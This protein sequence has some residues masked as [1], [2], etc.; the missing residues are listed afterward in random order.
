[1][2]FDQ[3]PS[4]SGH[5]FRVQR[6][7]GPVWYAKYRLPGGRQVKRKIGPAWTQR[8]RPAAGFA[9]KRIAEQWLGEVLAEARERSVPGALG[10]EATFADAAHEWLRYV[11]QDRACKP[12]TMRGYRSSVN[13]L[14]IPALRRHAHRRH[15]SRPH[16]AL[17]RIAHDSATDRNK[18]LVELHGILRRAQKLYGVRDNPAARV[19]PLRAPRRLD[20]QVYSPE[21][22][23][24]LVRAADSEQ[25][26]AIYL[27]AAL[28]TD[29]HQAREGR[30]VLRPRDS[31]ANKHLLP[32]ARAGLAAMARGATQAARGARRSARDTEPSPPAFSAT[33]ERQPGDAAARTTG[34]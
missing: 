29:G 21:E 28:P 14:L 24:A 2:R 6:K 15:H 17:A 31:Q 11:E 19:E 9:T 16:R 27:T 7:R 33:G 3:V 8:G 4:C 13:G 23:R 1:V 30:A 5:V 26:A 34:K 32:R 20:L 18:L 12:S 10:L 22:I 25:D